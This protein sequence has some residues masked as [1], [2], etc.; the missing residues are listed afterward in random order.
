MS[1]FAKARNTLRDEAH[2]QCFCLSKE[3]HSYRK[4]NRF[5]C[6][7]ISP[8]KKCNSSAWNIPFSH[9]DF[10]RL[11]IPESSQFIVHSKKSRFFV[12]LPIDNLSKHFLFLNSSI[13]KDFFKK[14]FVKCIFG[15]EKSSFVFCRLSQA[16]NSFLL[17][18][19]IEKTF[20]KRNVS[21]SWFFFYVEESCWHFLAPNCC[22][23][24]L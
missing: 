1:L 16:W 4:S 3:I 19:K 11:K 13:Q 7:E 24:T 6:Y 2:S 22:S 21:F 9:F 17:F 18:V 14:N 15:V 12:W 23:T 8:H 5:C 20:A 10:V